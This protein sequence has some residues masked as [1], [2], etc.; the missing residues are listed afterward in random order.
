MNRKERERGERQGREEETGD[1]GGER[2]K[3]LGGGD[4]VGREISLWR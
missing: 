1:R 4:R 3:E 2:D